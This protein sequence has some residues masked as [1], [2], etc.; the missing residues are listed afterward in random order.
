M[1]EFF[2]LP[3][4]YD[5]EKQKF[6]EH[7]NF[8]KNMS[9][10]ELT[11]YKKWI[12]IQESGNLID[13]SLQLKANIWVPQDIY[14]VPQTIKEIG[15]LNPEI[16]FISPSNK[17]AMEEWLILRTFIHTME[18]EQNPGRFLRFLIKDKET[19]KYLG[20]V[21]LGSDVLSIDCRDKWLGWS[22]ETKVDNGKLRHSAIATTIVATQPLGY[23]FL[24]GKLIASLLTL[25]VVRDT[26]KELYNE[27][28]VGITTTSLYGIHS[29]YQRIPFWKELGETVGKVMIK[30]DDRYYEFWH[31]WIKENKSEKYGL[32]TEG[33]GNGPATGV[34][35][36]IITLIMQ[37]LGL[38][39]SN[40]SHGF[41]RGVYYC[42]LYEN[43]KEFLC[44]TVD[45]SKLIL[46]K[47]IQ[48]DLS[49]VLNWWKPK[50]IDRYKKLSLEGKIKPEILYYNQLFGKSW[51]Q[52]KEQFLGEVGR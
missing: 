41:N 20:V 24:G 22:Y 21:S 35:Q 48:H 44:G 45:E 42:S 39:Q 30:P 4:S 17:L 50:A 2:E 9:N 27:Q 40:Y 26:W 28:L 52:T 15:N 51:E 23:N 37:E 43:T 34:K 46:N 6:I 11:L 5:E 1:S 38:K 25:P 19:Q 13:K 47:K 7:M 18:F 29:M 33:R 8:L 32:R 16:V 3:N 36:K 12:E 49:D 31:H 10:E 14:N